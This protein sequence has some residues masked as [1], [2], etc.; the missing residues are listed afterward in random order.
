MQS[1]RVCGSLCLRH[2]CQDSQRL[3]A[4]TVHQAKMARWLNPFVYLVSRRLSF[5]CY[6]C[7]PN[8]LLR[9]W[10][11]TLIK[12]NLLRLRLDY[13]LNRRGHTVVMILKRNPVPEDTDLVRP[14]LSY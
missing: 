9:D 11:Q 14:Q 3:L 13:A 7:S 1:G 6:F 4:V 2:V 10:L 12:T 8:T 5:N